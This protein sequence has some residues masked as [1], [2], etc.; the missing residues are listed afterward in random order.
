VA[1]VNLE[2]VLSKE[3]DTIVVNGVTGVVDPS[4]GL[5]QNGRAEVILLTGPPVRRAR[6]RA[7]STENALVETIKSL[8]L[9][10]ALVNLTLVDSVIKTWLEPWSNGLVLLV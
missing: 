5:E 1:L 8:A 10:L 2:L 9:S 3:L 6:S 4:V 7:A